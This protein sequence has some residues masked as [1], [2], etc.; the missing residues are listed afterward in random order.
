MGEFHFDIDIRM[1]CRLDY[2]V[3]IDTDHVTVFLLNK[4]ERK[5]VRIYHKT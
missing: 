4:W 1:L 3:N 5:F 2:I